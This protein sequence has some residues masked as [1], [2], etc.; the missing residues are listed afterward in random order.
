MTSFDWEEFLE[1]AAEQ[2]RRRGNPAAERSAIGR[3]AYAVFHLASW[4]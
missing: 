2:V 1:F 3:A 4:I